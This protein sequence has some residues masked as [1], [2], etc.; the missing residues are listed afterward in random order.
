[1]FKASILRIRWLASALMFSLFA[2]GA[3]VEGGS[4]GIGGAILSAVVATFWWWLV[5]RIPWSDR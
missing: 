5:V 1:M 3:A 4:V 2:V